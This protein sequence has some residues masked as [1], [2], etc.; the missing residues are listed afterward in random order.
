MAV[1]AQEFFKQKLKLKT[2]QEKQWNKFAKMSITELQV[3]GLPPLV[4][5]ISTACHLATFCSILSVPAVACRHGT[6][7]FC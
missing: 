2:E 3:R 5:L 6:W 7:R 1:L 4:C